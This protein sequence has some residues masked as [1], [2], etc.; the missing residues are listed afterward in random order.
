MLQFCGILAQGKK[1]KIYKKEEE[2]R[3]GEGAFPFRF[4]VNELA[5]HPTVRFPHFHVEEGRIDSR[6]RRHGGDRIFNYF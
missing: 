2:N 3:A 4:L 5:P 6:R 1:Q